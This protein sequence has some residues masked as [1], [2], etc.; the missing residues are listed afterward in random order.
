MSS[1]PI[2]GADG[3]KITRLIAAPR[4]KVF[5]A[6]TDPVE[7]KRWWGPPGFTTP[8]A[9]VDLRV[10]GAYRIAMKPPDGDV[11][12]VAGVY[13]EVQPPSKLVFT[14][15][16]DE[17]GAP[18]H[19]S[20]VTVFFIERGDATEVVFSHERLKDAESRDRHA[21]GWEALFASLA[22]YIADL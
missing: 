4:E 13:R 21:E 12:Y 7:I 6:W 19:E 11:I 15:A 2:A 14:W 1:G 17:D 9:E 22:A 5:K 18:G 3:I 10:G 16:W 20:L 8:L